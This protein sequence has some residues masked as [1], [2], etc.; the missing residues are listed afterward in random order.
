MD[1]T[2]VVGGVIFFVV[3]LSMFGS[4]KRPASATDEGRAASRITARAVR[5]RAVDDVVRRRNSGE[6]SEEDSYALLQELMV[7]PRPSGGQAQRP[8]RG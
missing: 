1:P 8:P 3:L 4:G 6:L 2:V 7:G 5:L